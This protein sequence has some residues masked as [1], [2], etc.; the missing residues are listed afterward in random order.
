DDFLAAGSTLDDLLALATETLHEPASVD[1]AGGLDEDASQADALV[2]IGSAASL[3]ADPLGTPYARLSVA[4]HHECWPLRSKG[5]RRWL[6]GAYHIETE[7]A[8]TGEAVTN[9]LNVLEAR[10]LGGGS[11]EPVFVRIAP[12]GDAGLYLDLGDADWRA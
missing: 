9:A 1:G 5:F 2:R 6:I 3:F 11:V 10:A 7:R 12:D 4:D 8:P